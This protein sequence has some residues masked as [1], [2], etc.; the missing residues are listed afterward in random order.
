MIGLTSMA[1]P[2]SLDVTW[3]NLWGRRLAVVGM[4]SEV[5]TI[6]RWSHQWLFQK[7]ACLENPFITLSRP[8]AFVTQNSDIACVSHVYLFVVILASYS[9]SELPCPA[10]HIWQGLLWNQQINNV[11]G[12][13]PPQDYKKA[14]LE[15][16]GGFGIPNHGLKIKGGLEWWPSFTSGQ[17]DLQWESLS[18][19]LLVPKNKES[20]VD[21][22]FGR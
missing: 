19:L 16:P 9:V 3:Y 20:A 21:R 15:A 11:C 2:L 22:S 4:E 17:A 12:F 18:W 1:L 7:A 8:P 6:V 5:I 13:F 14:V 10:G